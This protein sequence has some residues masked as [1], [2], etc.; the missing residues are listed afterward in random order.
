L[1]RAVVVSFVLILILPVYWA[2]DKGVQKV[3]VSIASKQAL[4]TA[5]DQAF[6]VNTFNLKLPLQKGTL[7]FD[8]DTSLDVNPIMR[9][10]MGLFGG[11]PFEH[12]VIF[13]YVDKI[14]RKT[15][16]KYH[17]DL[18]GK[19]YCPY[20]KNK[21]EPTREFSEEE[22]RIETLEDSR[23]ITVLGYEILVD[24]RVT[25]SGTGKIYWSSIDIDDAS[26]NPVDRFL[27]VLTGAL[28]PHYW[29]SKWGSS[30]DILG[31][32]TPE[33]M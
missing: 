1:K 31:R 16:L 30:V 18:C 25:V 17:M 21:F 32:S 2:V 27:R 9:R 5:S 24:F 33:E 3:A 11:T 6:W 8:T 29:V 10:T 19:D 28:P 26:R 23:V 22:T 13:V 15:W 20:D 4:E 14:G 7:Y 12:D